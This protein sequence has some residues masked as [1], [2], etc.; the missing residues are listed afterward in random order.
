MS[1]YDEGKI[2][3]RAYKP[4]PT[5]HRQE[6]AP[7]DHAA[8]MEELV[9]QVKDN[10]VRKLPTLFFT[11]SLA[12]RESMVFEALV[13][14]DF[15]CIALL[16]SGASHSFVSARFMH[17]NTIS[18]KAAQ[19]SARLADGQRLAIDGFVTK[20]PLKA[21]SMSWEQSFLVVSLPSYDMV[22]GM[23]FLMRFNPRSFWPQ[24]CMTIQQKGHT[25]SLHTS[26][27]AS[28]DA[29]E[30][31]IFQ[32]CSFDALARECRSSGDLSFDGAVLGCLNPQLNVVDACD[33][34][35]SNLQD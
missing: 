17:E 32:L 14:H 15:L 7:M 34:G 33:V 29:A 2:I 19:S 9:Y 16:D 35:A 30:S 10:S 5:N 8:E 25:H 13:M 31:S 3:F 20:F 11:R 6:L 1:N 4:L 12:G 23:D 18:Y 26:Q 21:G 27:P 22:W 24:R 28:R